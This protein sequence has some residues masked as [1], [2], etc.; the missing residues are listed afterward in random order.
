MSYLLFQ[1][2]INQNV[3]FYV[4]E[5]EIMS[6]KCQLSNKKGLVVRKVSHSKR[7]MNRVQRANLQRKRFWDED[8]KKWRRMRVTV[9]MIKT[10][11]KKGLGAV[12]KQCG[13]SD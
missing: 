11:S 12:L 6:R 5:R 9:E 3:N 13:V 1:P 7:H 10:I 8:A 4:S 2:K